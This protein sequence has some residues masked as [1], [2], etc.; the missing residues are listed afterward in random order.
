MNKLP[1]IQPERELYYNLGILLLIIDSLA[2]TKRQKKTLTIDKIQTFYFLVTRPV[3]LN[4]VLDLANKKKI[5]VD[6]S[7]FYTIDTLAVNVDE[8]FDRDRLLLLIKLLSSKN[9]LSA[10]Y[11]D[12]DGF[13]FE[14]NSSG[15]AAA[16]AIQ[17]GYFQKIRIFLTKISSLQSMSSSKLNGYINLAIKQVV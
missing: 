6:E 8:L 17:S 14:L 11:S 16:K 5:E 7:D 12:K 4:K 15:Q 3:F 9:Y 2:L 10:S 1:Y 13:V